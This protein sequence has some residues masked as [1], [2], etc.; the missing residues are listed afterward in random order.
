[1]WWPGQ[2]ADNN[3]L[4]VFRVQREPGFEYRVCVCPY[5]KQRLLL[6]AATAQNKI[7]TVIG[8]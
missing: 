6:V 5:T 3:A 8:L 2:A 4:S 1:M 7:V